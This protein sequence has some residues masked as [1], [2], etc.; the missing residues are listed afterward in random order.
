MGFDKVPYLKIFYTERY[1][2]QPN[3]IVIETKDKRIEVD[4]S[5]RSSTTS[6]ILRESLR[7]VTKGFTLDL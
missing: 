1:N 6:K 7:V 2:I 4:S 5:Y 3:L